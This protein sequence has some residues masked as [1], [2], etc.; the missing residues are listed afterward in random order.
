MFGSLCLYT[1]TRS[2]PTGRIKQIRYE[3]VISFFRLL[4]VAVWSG[5]F[6]D[7]AAPAPPKP[8]KLSTQDQIPVCPVSQNTL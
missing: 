4:E 8:R 2:G 1:T 3:E 5:S 7:V 6:D